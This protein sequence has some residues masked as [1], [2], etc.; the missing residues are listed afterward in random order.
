MFIYS[1]ARKVN[2]SII[3]PLRPWLTSVLNV[4][5]WL[6]ISDNLIIWKDNLAICVEWPNCR[7]FFRHQ[8]LR[9]KV[10]FFC[11]SKV[12]FLK[13]SRGPLKVKLDTT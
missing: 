2:L 8:V 1:V 10:K 11:P 12:D 7:L 13:K 4:L 6:T 3:N 9:F 5:L